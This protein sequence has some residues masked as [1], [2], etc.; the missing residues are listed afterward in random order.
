MGEIG[1][2]IRKAD[3]DRITSGLLGAIALGL[4]QEKIAT[5]S[6]IEFDSKKKSHANLFKISK[7][8]MP[9]GVTMIRFNFGN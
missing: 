2:S 5:D 1:K 4:R 9:H 6:R 7:N 3:K 8:L